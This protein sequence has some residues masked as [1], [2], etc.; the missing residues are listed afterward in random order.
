MLETRNWTP[1]LSG[2]NDLP[3]EIIPLI[4]QHIVRP[5]HLAEICLVDKVFYSAA[6]PILYE[7]TTI[8]AWHKN[9][10]TKVG[11]RTRP[12]ILSLKLRFTIVTR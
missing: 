9:A 12:K 10:K 6:I 5:Q 3:L 4:V 2:F 11:A 1:I 7:R 8:F